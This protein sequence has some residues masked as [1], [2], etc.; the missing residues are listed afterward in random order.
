MNIYTFSLQSVLNDI[1]IVWRVF[2]LPVLEPMTPARL[3]K[4]VNVAMGCMYTAITTATANLV[5]AMATTVQ[6]KGTPPTKDEECE[7]FAANIVQ[8]SVSIYNYVY[9][10]LEILFRLKMFS[11]KTSDKTDRIDYC[12]IYIDTLILHN[13]GFSLILSCIFS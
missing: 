11:P 10:R 13:L 1:T 12:F 7:A 4:I 9:V 2:S 8:K 5:V 3:D 6:T